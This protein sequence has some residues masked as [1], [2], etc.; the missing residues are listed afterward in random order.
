[1][2]V[3][4]RRYLAG[5]WMVG[6]LDSFWQMFTPLTSHVLSG[7]ILQVLSYLRWQI[8]TIS[9]TRWAPSLLVNEVVGPI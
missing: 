2:L 1:M 9:Y 8:S 3:Y 7:V 4:Q 5:K 6:I